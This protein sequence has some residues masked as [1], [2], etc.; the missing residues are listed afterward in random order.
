VEAL[1]ERRIGGAGLDVMYEEP[2]PTDDPLHALNEDP[3]YNV[4]LTSHT[5]WQGPWT[6]VRDSLDIWLNVQRHLRGEPL[7]YVV[8]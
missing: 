5:G 1:R 3:S 2:M 4:T 7:R 6:W 8:G